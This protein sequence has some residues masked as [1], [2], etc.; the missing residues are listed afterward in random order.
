MKTG[1]LLQPFAHLCRLNICSTIWKF[2]EVWCWYTEGH[3]AQTVPWDSLEEKKQDRG[4]NSGLGCRNR[5]VKWALNLQKHLSIYVWTTDK[6]SI[7]Y[8]IPI[9][10]RTTHCQRIK[11][12]TEKISKNIPFMQKVAPFTGVR[13][14]EHELYLASSVISVHVSADVSWRGGCCG[15]FV[16]LQVWQRMQ[17]SLMYTMFIL[18]LRLYR[19]KSLHRQN[20]SG[21]SLSGPKPIGTKPKRTK[22]V[23]T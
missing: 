21:Q 13:E 11:T 16:F 18:K 8:M 1:H 7:Q 6:L 10:A 20:Q 4:G 17:F 5:R 23:G 2:F 3:V 19:N 12:S 22:P 9:S 14:T 15:G